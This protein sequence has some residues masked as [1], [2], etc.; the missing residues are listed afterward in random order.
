M[1][2]KKSKPIEPLVPYDEIPEEER[3][4]W[5]NPEALASVRRGLADAAAGRVHYLGS[6]AKYI[7][8]DDDGEDETLYLMKSPATYA[9][10]MESIENVKQGHVV[11]KELLED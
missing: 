1:K 9:H 7:N 3:W 6:F 2:A 10:L 4:L 8:D 5:D 11:I